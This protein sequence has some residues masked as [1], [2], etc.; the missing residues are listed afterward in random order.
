M[1]NNKNNKNNQKEQSTSSRE[2]KF[3][4]FCPRDWM[5]NVSRIDMQCSLASCY[6]ELGDYMP[7][8]YGWEYKE[9]DLMQYTWLKDKNWKEIY[10]GDIL[11][12]PQEESIIKVH[13]NITWAC[14]YFDVLNLFMDDWHG[15]GDWRFTMSVAKNS[16]I[17]WNM[18]ENHDL[19]E[20]V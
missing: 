8:Y 1:E 12:F 2:I 3:R 18:H 20:T 9:A 4:L 19:L 6:K 15:R 13:W 17:I 16:T 11:E 7:K 5:L 10:E 14:R